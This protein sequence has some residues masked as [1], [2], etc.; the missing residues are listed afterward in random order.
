MTGQHVTTEEM[1]ARLVAFDTTSRDGNIPLDRI[2]RGLSRRLGRTAF[3]R[4]LRGGQEDQSL[5][6]HRAG[7]R[8]RHRA[9]GPHRRRAGR[10]PG[11]DQRS[12]R[13]DGARRPALRPRH[14]R[15]EGLPRRLPRHGAALQGGAAEI[16][17]PS[18]ALLRRGSGLQ[19]RAPAGGA[20]A[21]SSA[22]AA[23]RDRRRADLDEGGQR[24]QERHHLLHRRHRPRGAFQ[25]ASTRASM[26]SWWRASCCPSS[27]ASAP[28]SSRAA[29]PA[30]ASIRPIRRCMSA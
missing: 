2:R 18:G 7:H 11:L 30:T 5:R 26:P 6:H 14:L 27:T 13:A 24:P 1:L 20:S 16:A 9:L 12:L 21:R 25:P 10:R 28:I 23:R 4:R 19:G 3:P 8:G 17:H 29:I 15:H 22:E